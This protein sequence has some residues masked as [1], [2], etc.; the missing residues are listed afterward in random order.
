MVGALFSIP[1][2]NM[3]NGL[4]AARLWGILNRDARTGLSVGTHRGR[5]ED[6][7]LR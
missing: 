5:V 1:V 2:A 6:H 3:K 4:V 7:G